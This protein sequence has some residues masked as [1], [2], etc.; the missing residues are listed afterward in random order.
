MYNWLYL[1]LYSKNIP[2]FPHSQLY[3]GKCADMNDQYYVH[4]KNHNTQRAKT[5][6]RF[7]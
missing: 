4:G 3:L 1:C 6:S 7:F 5:H 2:A